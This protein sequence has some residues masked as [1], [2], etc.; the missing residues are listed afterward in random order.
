M[1]PVAAQHKEG[2]LAQ[3]QSVSRAMQQQQ[4]QQGLLTSPPKSWA[5]DS[6]AKSAS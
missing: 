2:G 1:H 6:K 4:Q 5:E 3:T